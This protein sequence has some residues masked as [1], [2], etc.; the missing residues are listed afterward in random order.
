MK[1]IF[2]TW[3]QLCYNYYDLLSG[4]ICNIYLII[5]PIFGCGNQQVLIICLSSIYCFDHATVLLQVSIAVVF[6]MHLK[7]FV[8]SNTL[9][10]PD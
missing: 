8:F 10:F 1:E 7:L 6:H 2:Q 4:Y 3:L 5:K 9:C